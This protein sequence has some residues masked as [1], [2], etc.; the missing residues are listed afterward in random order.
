MIIMIIT[1]VI[2]NENNDNNSDNSS[3]TKWK[4]NFKDNDKNSKAMLG[5]SGIITADNT[6]IAMVITTNE[7]WV[8]AQDSAELVSA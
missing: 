5:E 2:Q 3:D 7:E 1:I 6:P 4:Q 8:I